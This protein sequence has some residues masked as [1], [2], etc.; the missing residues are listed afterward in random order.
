MLL[1]SA[2]EWFL[3]PKSMAWALRVRCTG[4]S[5]LVYC[6][7]CEVCVLAY[8]VVLLHYLFS[9]CEC[10]CKAWKGPTLCL[11]TAC[12]TARHT[13]LRC[14]VRLARDLPQTSKLIPLPNR[15]RKLF[16]HH[17][18]SHRSRLWDAS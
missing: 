1:R 3:G 6:G 13:L 10:P 9:T 5:L 17:P 16:G 2:W 18:I 14:T 12:M 11:W 8:V 7:C 4:A 15:I